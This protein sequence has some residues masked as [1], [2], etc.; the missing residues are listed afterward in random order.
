MIE[1]SIAVDPKKWLH[2]YKMDE[3][4]RR[5]PAHPWFVTS[6]FSFSAKS[7]NVLNCLAYA[8]PMM[9][10]EKTYSLGPD[11]AA[12]SPSEKRLRPF[13]WNMIEARLS[14]LVLPYLSAVSREPTR[15][16]IL[17]SAPE[18]NAVQPSTR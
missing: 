14:M 8:A 9:N 6:I 10:A 2:N 12:V 18:V 4:K 5:P 11:M 7:G 13:A 1:E 3:A 15:L 16:Q 17:P